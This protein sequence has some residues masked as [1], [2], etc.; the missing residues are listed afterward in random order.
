MDNTESIHWPYRC[1]NETKISANLHKAQ[2]I[3]MTRMKHGK[4]FSLKK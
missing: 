2:N 1:T 3:K 4:L